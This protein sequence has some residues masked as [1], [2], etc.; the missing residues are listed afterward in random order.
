MQLHVNATPKQSLEALDHT[1]MMWYVLS[2][3][4]TDWRS[5]EV[6]ENGICRRRFMRLPMIS[7]S[8]VVVAWTENGIGHVDVASDIVQA[9]QSGT[10]RLT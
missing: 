4:T 8:F 9:Y 7:Y 1:E 2:R 6:W 10:I 3:W 5:A